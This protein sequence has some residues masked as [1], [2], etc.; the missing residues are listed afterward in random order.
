MNPEKGIQIKTVRCF[1]GYTDLQALHKNEY[2]EPV[3]FVSTRNNHHRAIYRDKKGKLHDSTVTF[4]DAVERRRAGLPVIVTEPGKYFEWGTDDQKLLNGLPQP[5]WQYITL[6][7]QDELFAF[8][9]TLEDLEDAINSR[10]CAL[11]SKHLYRVQKM[12]K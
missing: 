8:G 4:W 10:N 12:S 2:G 11:I 5:D 1:T 3:D 6:L 7:Q 9:I